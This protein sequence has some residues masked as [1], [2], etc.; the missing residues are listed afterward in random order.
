M[1]TESPDPFLAWDKKT[2]VFWDG[3]LLK[4]LAMVKDRAAVKEKPLV[5]QG[6]VIIIEGETVTTVE[7]ATG[8]KTTM[9]GSAASQNS[10]CPPVAAGRYL[11]SVAGDRVER[12]DLATGEKVTAAERIFSGPYRYCASM[13]ADDTGNTVVLKLYSESP[14]EVDGDCDIGLGSECWEELEKVQAANKETTLSVSAPVATE[15]QTTA[16]GPPLCTWSSQASSE[17]STSEVEEK[18][19]KWLIAVADASLKVVARIPIPPGN[20]GGT[21]R[22][23][24]K[25]IKSSGGDSLDWCS[26]A[27]APRLQTCRWMNEAAFSLCGVNW[28]TDSQEYGWERSYMWLDEQTN[29]AWFGSVLSP[30]E[31][32]QMSPSGCWSWGNTGPVGARPA[33]MGTGSLEFVQWVPGMAVSAVP[34]GGGNH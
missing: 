27:N 28:G 23:V 7:L 6:R 9:S 33:P 12:L 30:E 24:A 2:L 11:F 34:S 22:D 3:K 29:K 31:G 26:E 14:L 5:W 17:R 10:T 8:R 25:C 16:V 15:A 21:P 18:G 32:I 20:Y 19:D 4:K 13:A 1:R